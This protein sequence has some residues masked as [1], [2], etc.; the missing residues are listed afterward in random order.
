MY[1]LKV[2][3]KR[4]KIMEKQ[5]VFYKILS[6]PILYRVFQTAVGGKEPKIY[7]IIKKICQDFYNNKGYKPRLLDLGC[8]EGKL[9]ESVYEYSDYLGVDYSEEYLSHARKVYK[10]KGS[11]ITYNLSSSDDCAEISKNA[12]FI[13][14]IGLLHHLASEDILKIKENIFESNPNAILLTIDPV[15]LEKQ[16]RIARFLVSKDRGSFVRYFTKYQEL[17]TDYKCHLDNFCRIPYNHI[18]FYRNVQLNKYL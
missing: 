8:G 17:F 12:D 15:L 18:L 16:G 9:C 11:F 14:A 13:V 3:R 1:S 4:G 10:D 6:N 7:Q 2:Y 5:N